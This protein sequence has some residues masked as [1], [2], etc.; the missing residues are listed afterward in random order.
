MAIRFLLLVCFFSLFAGCKKQ[1]YFFIEGLAQGT[2]YHVTYLGDNLFDKEIDSILRAFDMSLSAWEANSILSKINRNDSLVKA[3]KLFSDVFFKAKEVNEASGGMFDITV[4]PLVKA[5]GFYDTAHAIHDS[6]TIRNLLRLVG[7]QKVKLVGDKVVK[8]DPGIILDV[9]AIAQGYSVDVVSSFLEKHKVKNYLVEIG[10][11]LKAYGKNPEGKDWRVGIDKPV[12]GSA[13]PG[14]NLQVIIKIKHKALATSGDYRRFIIENGVKYAH[15]IN[16][17]TG[18]PSKSSLLSVSVLADDCI[19]A[20]AYGT[21]IMV[22]G[23]DKGKQLL[24]EKKLEGYFVYN[25]ERGNYQYF[26][27]EGFRKLIE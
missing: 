13:L 12:D 21:A 22:L 8:D 9:N 16:P 7:M 1:T 26:A 24:K 10:G 19:T 17:K 5:W 27:T 4:G 11:E 3:D 2:T 15:H 14:S 18:Y 25:D 6:I 23:L 20:D